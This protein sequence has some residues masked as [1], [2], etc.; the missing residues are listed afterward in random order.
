MVIQPKRV[1]G[2]YLAISQEMEG[3]YAEEGVHE[4]VYHLADVLGGRIIVFVL[5]D[6][7]LPDCSQRHTQPFRNT[8]RVAAARFKTLITGSLVATFD[9]FF[10]RLL[11]T[12]GASLLCSTSCEGRC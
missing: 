3:A 2:E 1:F 5:Q 7:Y 12:R 8:Y 10:R 11:G 6:L 9:L 4:S